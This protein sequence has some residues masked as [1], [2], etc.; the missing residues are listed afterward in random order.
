MKKYFDSEKTNKMFFCLSKGDID[1]ALA[2]FEQYKKDYPLDRFVN[3]YYAKILLAMGEKY[4]ALKICEGLLEERFHNNSQKKLVYVTYADI[5]TE[6]EYYDEALEYYNKC[7]DLT[8]HNT[9]K[10]QCSISHVYIK[11]N[12]PYESIKILNRPCADVD[13][14]KKN[15]YLS[16]AY[17]RVGNYKMVESLLNTV[18]DSSLDVRQRQYKCFLL[19][20][21]AY[22]RNDYEEAANFAK[23]GLTTENSLYYLNKSFVVSCYYKQNRYTDALSYCD[24]IIDKGLDYVDNATILNIIKTYVRLN[25]KEKLLEAI[26]KMKEQWQKSYIYG[27]ISLL[28]QRYQE[29]YN[30]FEDAFIDCPKYCINEI[31][32]CKVVAL[33][34]L[35][36]YDKCLKLIDSILNDKEVSSNSYV[37]KT[38]RFIKEIVLNKGYNRPMIRDSY[39]GRQISNYSYDDAIENIRITYACNIDEAINI[40]NEAA[41]RINTGNKVLVS[42]IDIYLVN[43]NILDTNIKVSTLPDSKNIISI[44]SNI[45]EEEEKEE[46]KE[47]VCE[48]PKVKRLTQIEKFNQRYGLK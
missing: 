28:Y 34:R 33:Y 44:S 1:G 35:G 10:V 18:K 41:S 37:F 26:R 6:N 36:E 19:A 38:T 9:F 31:R 15:Y 23:K 22:S 32:Y 24:E 7:L 5:L 14:D 46:V 12:L 40:Y 17:Y 43:S 11:K 4:K 2:L 21:S 20:S 29:A 45:C 30:Y 8:S 13:F 16:A 42:D 48:K 39:I 47:Y 3:A 25:E 27:Y